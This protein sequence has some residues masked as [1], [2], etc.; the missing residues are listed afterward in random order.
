MAEEPLVHA[1]MTSFGDVMPWRD[2]KGSD[3]VHLALGGVMM[4]CGYDPRPDGSYDL[5]PIA[6]QMWHA[7]HIVAA[8]LHKRR[9]GKGQ[10]VAC[11]VHE[12]VTKAPETDVMNWVMR[13]APV[14]RQT[15]RHA[16]ETVN[17]LP[18][19]SHMKDGRWYTALSISAR[20]KVALVP[21]LARYGM[22]ADL[23]EEK[24]ASEVGGRAI[25]G[26]AS[27]DDAD[28]LQEVIQRFV[29]AYRY[30]EMPW[31][32]AQN[33]GLLWAPLRKPHENVADEHWRMRGTFAQVEHP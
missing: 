23:T 26:M 13:R 31:R 3:L 6:P 18:N 9:T 28:H 1:R 14:Y 19:I 21:F 4:N 8:L 7:Y 29:R 15:C 2:F 27:S 5:P 10:D 30:E 24:A 22:A 25:P 33:A 11:A 12:A 16:L 32:E 20:D 17:R